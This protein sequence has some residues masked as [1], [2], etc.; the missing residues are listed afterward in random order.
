MIIFS[1]KESHFLKNLLLLHDDAVLASGTEWPQQGVRLVLGGG[2]SN[3]DEGALENLQ[4]CDYLSAIS[5][6]HCFYCT[7]KQTA[8][9]SN[10]DYLAPVAVNMFSL[11]H[12]PLLRK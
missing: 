4:E 9:L 10:C 7:E 2:G 1:Y 5:C 6:A 11:L 12:K 3:G 8:S